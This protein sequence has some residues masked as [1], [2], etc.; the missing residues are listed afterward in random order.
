M[1]LKLSVDHRVPFDGSLNYDFINFQHC[2]SVDSEQLDSLKL[3]CAEAFSCRSIPDA[4]E[5][6]S[7]GST[8]FVVSEQS[9]RC[10]LEKL[11]LTIF[12]F[13]TKNAIY[14]PEKSGAEWWTQVIDCRD[15]IGFHWDRDYGKQL[16][17][18]Y[19]RGLYEYLS[20]LK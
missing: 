20:T 2:L 3:D 17:E 6:Y 10:F 15:D 7:T 14:D 4:N 18:C 1:V 12:R 5:N 9:P 11:A 16:Q 19:M 8:Y 13:H